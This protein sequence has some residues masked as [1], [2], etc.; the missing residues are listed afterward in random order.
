MTGRFCKGRCPIKPGMTS[1]QANQPFRILGHGVVEC[2]AGVGMRL[3]IQLSHIGTFDGVECSALR[4]LLKSSLLRLAVWTPASKAKGPVL[5]NGGLFC[6]GSFPVKPGMTSLQANQAFRIFRH[7]VIECEACVG[8]R[9]RIQLS[10]IGTFDGVECS[11]LR[12]LLKSSLLRLAVWTPASKAKKAPFF[13][14]GAFFVK[15]VSRSSRE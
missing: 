11:A 6:K 14:T 4:R 8:M 2:V 7:G 5:S 15:G 10:H 13:R 12:R 9:L 1:L 3:R